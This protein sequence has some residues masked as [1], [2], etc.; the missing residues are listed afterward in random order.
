MTVLIYN[1]GH[2]TSLGGTAHAAAE[3]L[4]LRNLTGLVTLSARTAV[5]CDGMLVDAAYKVC[6]NYVLTCCHPVHSSL[7]HLLCDLRAP[8]K[9]AQPAVES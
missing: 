5:T 1:L 8:C 9:P 7:E 3:Q 2:H 6:A 4:W